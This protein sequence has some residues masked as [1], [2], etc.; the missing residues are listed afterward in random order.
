M[1]RVLRAFTDGKVSDTKDEGGEAA[2]IYSIAIAVANGIVTELYKVIE[3][4]RADLHYRR[5]LLVVTVSQPA[6]TPLFSR[7]R[8]PTRAPPR[9]G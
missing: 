5:H 8:T 4:L 1:I 9:A 2:E 3:V 6:W 7:S